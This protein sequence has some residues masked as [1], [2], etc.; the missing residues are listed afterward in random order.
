MQNGGKTLRDLLFR[1]VEKSAALAEDV[2][3]YKRVG[4]QHPDHSYRFLR[5]M[6]ER[7]VENSH[8]RK[9]VEAHRSAIRSGRNNMIETAPANPATTTAGG[10]SGA[11]PATAGPAAPASAE[12]GAPK[13]KRRQRSRPPPGSGGGGGKKGGEPPKEGQKTDLKEVPCYFHSAAKYGV[14]KGCSKGAACSF[15]HGKFLSKGRVRIG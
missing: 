12:S 5:D 7:S 2:A 9:I 6:I 15:S 1:Q 11:P 8:Q 13:P 14:G 3:H 10:G 4:K